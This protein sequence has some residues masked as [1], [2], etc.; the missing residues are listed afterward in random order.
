MEIRR[1]ALRAASAVSLTALAIGAI[2][3]GGVVVET[4]EGST[5]MPAPS[6]SATTTTTTTA[7]DPVDAGT[8]VAD[9]GTD[10]PAC[11]CKKAQDWTACCDAV[12]WA[13]DCGCLAWGPPMPP[14]MR[15]AMEVS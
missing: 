8:T 3:C 4:E 10:A 12:S 1:R 2:G 13:T 14:E 7:P 15:S 9:A 5:D 11:D 6:A